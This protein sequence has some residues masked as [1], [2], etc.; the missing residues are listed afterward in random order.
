MQ[1]NQIPD[2]LIVS[3]LFWITTRFISLNKIN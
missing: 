3:K 1:M 2:C